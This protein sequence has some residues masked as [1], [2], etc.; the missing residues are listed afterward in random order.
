MLMVTW[1][2]GNQLR[3]IQQNNQIYGEIFVANLLDIIKFPSEVSDPSTTLSEAGGTKMRILGVKFSNITAPR[4]E[5]GTLIK[6]IVGYEILRGS[7]EGNKS[8]LAKGYY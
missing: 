2:I 3:D 8:I 6:N 1:H 4:Y 5:D 7:R